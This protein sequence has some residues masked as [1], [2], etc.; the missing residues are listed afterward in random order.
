M[1]DAILVQKGV[2]VSNASSGTFSTL[3]R[4]LVGGVLPVDVTRGWAAADLKANGRKVHVVDSHFEAFDSGSSNTG[5]DGR[6]TP[7]A[8]SARPR[9]SS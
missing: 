7:R 9:P 2:K 8:A 1:R 4:V 6:P 3:L 5:S